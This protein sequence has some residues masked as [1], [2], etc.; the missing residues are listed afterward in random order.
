MMS[1]PSI[2]V[3]SNWG[4]ASG[5]SPQD[6]PAR[7]FTVPSASPGTIKFVNVSATGTLRY[8]KNGGALT[9]VVDLATLSVATGDT[10]SFRLTGS[11]DTGSL[12]VNDATTGVSIGSW[13]ATVT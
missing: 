11:G 5:A 4:V 1:A 3:D 7:T 13:S 2:T 12:G 10:L 6:S 9:A 8:S